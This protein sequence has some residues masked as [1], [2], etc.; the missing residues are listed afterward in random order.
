MWPLVEDK[1]LERSRLCGCWY[2]GWIMLWEGHLAARTLRILES[3]GGLLCHSACVAENFQ[4]CFRILRILETLGGG[5]GA[6]SSSFQE[7]TDPKKPAIAKMGGLAA[8]WVKPQ[9]ETRQHNIRYGDA[10]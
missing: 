5:V 2:L 1:G 3:L 10:S 6:S 7:V 8:L 9:N 4:A